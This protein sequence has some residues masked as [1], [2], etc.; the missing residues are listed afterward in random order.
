MIDSIDRLLAEKD[1]KDWLGISIPTLHRMRANGTGPCFVQLS[2]RRIAYRKS[3]I[4]AW[5]T[6]RTTDRIG[7]VAA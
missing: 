1:V 4:E 3:D 5:I 6:Q 7:G 2:T